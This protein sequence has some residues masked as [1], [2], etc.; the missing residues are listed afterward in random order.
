M[1]VVRRAHD[2]G[3]VAQREVDFALCRSGRSLEVIAVRDALRVAENVVQDPRCT[4]GVDGDGTKCR[5]DDRKVNILRA[6]FERRQ[7]PDVGRTPAAIAHRA[8]NRVASREQRVLAVQ[9]VVSRRETRQRQRR[10]EASRPREP[11]VRRHVVSFR[12]LPGQK[13]HVVLVAVGRHDD[14]RERQR[15]PRD[16]S[17]QVGSIGHPEAGEAVVV[18]VDL[19]DVRR[20]AA[21]SPPATTSE[22]V[23]CNQDHQPAEAHTS[24]LAAGDGWL[25]MPPSHDGWRCGKRWRA[26]LRLRNSSRVAR[27][28]LP[29]GVLGMVSFAPSLG[30]LFALVACPGRAYRLCHPGLISLPS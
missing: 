21:A 28:G 29:A 10:L 27:E 3:R 13:R 30:F 22:E 23:E 19:D 12:V 2:V 7:L 26:R 6:G 9:Q 20:G 1:R 5:S 17:L 18:D 15:S 4:L 14:P 25:K 8:V 24:N 16:E 11:G